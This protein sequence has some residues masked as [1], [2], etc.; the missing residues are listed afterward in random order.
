MVNQ[1][2][3]GESFIIQEAGPE[4]FFIRGAIDGYEGW[5]SK[6]SIAGLEEQPEE[7]IINPD[8]VIASLTQVYPA[9]RPADTLLLLPGSTLPGLNHESGEFMLGENKYRVEGKLEPKPELANP[10]GIESIALEFVNAPYLWGGRGIFGI[11][12]SG[13]TQ[14]VYKIC[15]IKLPRDAGQQVKEGL[16]VN[17]VSE[18]VPG[19]LAF[20]GESEEEITH[21]GIILDGGRIIHASGKV[22]IDR[23]D[24]QGIFVKEKGS[25]SHSLRVIHNYL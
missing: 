13:F 17:F 25:Y 7:G 6:G 20:F 4:W 24:H 12:C 2:L 8:E 22:R 14:V 16:A 15:G 23:F 9:E 19:D 18:S 11:D 1:L 10:H 21:V 3:F 5:I